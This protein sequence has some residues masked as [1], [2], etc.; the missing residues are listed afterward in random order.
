MT[1][2]TLAIILALAMAAFMGVAFAG[3]GN[4]NEPAAETTAPAVVETTTPA[5]VEAASIHGDWLWEG[6]VFYRFNPDGTGVR[7]VNNILGEGAAPIAWATVDGVLYI[8]TTP[9]HCEIFTHGTLEA[10]IE[11]EVWSYAVT[12]A[13]LTITSQQVEGMTFT[14]TRGAAAASFYGDW[15]WDGQVFYRFNPDGTGIRDVNN[16]LGEGAVAIAWATL[17]GTLY[18]CWTPDYC[19]IFAHGTIEACPE[20]EMWSY[21]LTANSLTITSQQVADMTFTYTR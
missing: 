10:C 3:C 1:K 17:D 7:D 19:E 9:D 8:C 16:I 12:A 6:Q 21:V 4:N 18:I 11:P 5:D 14:Y 13:G 2:R 15:L 20:P